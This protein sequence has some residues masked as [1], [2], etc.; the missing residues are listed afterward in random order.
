MN[1]EDVENILFKGGFDPETEKQLAEKTAEADKIISKPFNIFGEVESDEE[2]E[3]SDK[4]SEE[5][6]DSDEQEEADEE[7]PKSTVA[8]LKQQNKLLQQ[9]MTHLMGSSIK[10]MSPEEQRALDTGKALLNLQ[11][12]N[13]VLY[14]KLN[15]FIREELSGKQSQNVINNKLDAVRQM[16]KSDKF[17]EAGDLISPFQDMADAIELAEGNTKKE[18][19]QLLNI[20]NTLQREVGELKKDKETIKQKEVETFERKAYN[21]LEQAQKD[22]GLKIKQGSEEA[23]DLV[24]LIRNGRDPRKA[25]MKIYGLKESDA[26]KKK[27][28]KEV[29]LNPTGDGTVQKTGL[30]EKISKQLFPPPAGK[31]ADIFRKK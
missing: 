30:K 29:S 10:Q 6:L 22:F 9:Q 20:I 23:K 13:L 15:N 12:N 21:E 24:L 28:T 5:E 31:A 8:L 3:V 2:E 11:N 25:F 14:N 4:Q 1:R 7:E 18:N 27:P 19:Q 16:L 17:K 26:N